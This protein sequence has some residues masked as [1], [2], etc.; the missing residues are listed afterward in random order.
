MSTLTFAFTIYKGTTIYYPL[1]TTVSSITSVS[2][3]MGAPNF[4]YQVINPYIWG[5][6][7]LKFIITPNNLI[8]TIRITF[9]SIKWVS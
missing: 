7:P 9:P 5:I 1:S 3:I 4:T 8:D 6:S 2:F